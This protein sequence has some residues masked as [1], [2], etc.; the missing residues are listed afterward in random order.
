MKWIGTTCIVWLHS[1]GLINGGHVIA[2]SMHLQSP[3]QWMVTMWLIMPCTCRS[4][5]LLKEHL[6][7]ECKD[8]LRLR[9]P[10]ATSFAQPTQVRT[11]G[12]WHSHMSCLTVACR[13]LISVLVNND[14][15]YLWTNIEV[16]ERLVPESMKKLE[17]ACVKNMWRWLSWLFGLHTL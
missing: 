15:T 10:C 2:Y 11:L 7:D 4:P 5:V 1:S 6:E 16:C 17:D 14:Y 3:V 9:L 13:P 12:S 8:E